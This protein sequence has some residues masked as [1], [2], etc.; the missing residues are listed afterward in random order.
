VAAT[1]APPHRNRTWWS[2]PSPFAPSPYTSLIK[3]AFRPVRDERRIP[4]AV[5]LYLAAHA[6]PSA[7]PGCGCHPALTGGSRLHLLTPAAPAT[8]PRACRRDV[9]P[10]APRRV[11]GRPGYHLA[12]TD[13]SLKPGRAPTGPLHSRSQFSY[14]AR[15]VDIMLAQ[16]YW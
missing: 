13:G 1:C 6:A 5:P 12:A 10:T 4:S 3:K 7:A 16:G 8:A 14:T 9:G 2:A 11:S 15:M